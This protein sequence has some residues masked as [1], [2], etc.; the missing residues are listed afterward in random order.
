M[1]NLTESQK[2]QLRKR[3]GYYKSIKLEDFDS[4]DEFH[5]ERAEVKKE[6]YDLAKSYGLTDDEV[7]NIHTLIYSP[8]QLE[9]IRDA[10]DANGKL[11]FD[12]SGRGM[13]GDVCP[14]LYCDSHN[15]ITTKA[16]TQM[17]SMGLGIVI[18]AQY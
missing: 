7:S 17:D 10:I 4:R 12:Y 15:D 16:K 8:N 11:H 2:S 18:Y 3:Y 9:F 14:A 13:F 1:A 5:A 6:L